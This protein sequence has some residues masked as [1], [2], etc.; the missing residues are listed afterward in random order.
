M[1]SNETLFTDGGTAGDS[2][3]STI[4]GSWDVLAPGDTITFTGSYTVTLIDAGNL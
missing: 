4:D 2:T 3:D 1:P